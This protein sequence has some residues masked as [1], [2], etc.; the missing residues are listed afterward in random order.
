MQA[1]EA[2]IRD[3]KAAYTQFLPVLLRALGG[4]ARRGFAVAPADG[5]DFIHDFFV[6]Q[7]ENVCSNFDPN[8]GSFEAYVYGAFLNFARPR[9]VRLRR[10][11]D[12]LVDSQWLDSTKGQ[13]D[14]ENQVLSALDTKL[15]T[16]AIQA[17]PKIEREL[18]IAFLYAEDGSERSVARRFA[19][20]RYRVREILIDALGRIVTVFPKPSSIGEADWRVA[21][22]IWGERRT[23]HETAA[24]FGM[25]SHAVKKSMGRS[26][27]LIA[28]MLRQF[29]LVGSGGSSMNIPQAAGNAGAELL[30]KTLSSPGDEQLLADL[31]LSAKE[32][33]A[34]IESADLSL[35]TRTE[36]DPLWTAR[37]YEALSEVAEVPPTAKQLETERA[38]HEVENADLTTIGKAFTQTL[39]PDL[40][41]PLTRFNSFFS[42]LPRIDKNEYGLLADEPDVK[43]AFPNSADLAVFGIRPLSVFYASEAVGALFDRLLRYELIEESDMFLS[44]KQTGVYAPYL[45]K[46]LPDVSI[47][48]EIAR[49]T[50]RPIGTSTLLLKWLIAVSE[51]KSFVFGGFEAEVGPGGGVLL[52][53]TLREFPDLYQRWAVVPEYV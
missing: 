20:S 19:I 35:S 43:A 3:F 45:T 17:L 15:L 2:A 49:M 34:A 24:M 16:A 48:K 4:L 39:L 28:D 14:T 46:R 33:L 32:V 23:V 22:S 27:F 8:K 26:S 31:K 6:D 12:S 11:Q 53:R 5:I 29:Q 50:D 37:V 36:L 51:Y 1:G 13:Q 9:I 30:R 38:L 7:W 52:K 21:R 25:P 18:L 40:P 44:G 47:E 41:I 42:T 10:L